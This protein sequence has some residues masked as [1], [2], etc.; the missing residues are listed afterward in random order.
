MGATAMPNPEKLGHWH[1]M[2]VFKQSSRCVLTFV[3]LGILLWERGKIEGF[4][5]KMSSSLAVMV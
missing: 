4:H 2:D 1:Y 3:P 5:Q